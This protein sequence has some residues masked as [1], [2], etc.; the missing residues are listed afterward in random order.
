MSRD[1][2]I[3]DLSLGLI[4]SIFITGLVSPTA[5]GPCVHGNGELLTFLTS[6]HESTWVYTYTTVLTQ[7]GQ[8]NVLSLNIEEFHNFNETY[9]SILKY[10]MATMKSK[11]FQICKIVCITKY[12]PICSVSAKAKMSRRSIYNKFASC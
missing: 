8:H 3:S 4:T 6:L 11:L 10:S 1:T 12:R 5:S 2:K 7:L 9:S